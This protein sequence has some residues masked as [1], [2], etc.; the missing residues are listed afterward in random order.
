MKIPCFADH[1][2][3]GPFEHLDTVGLKIPRST[4]PDQEASNTTHKPHKLSKLNIAVIV[5]IVGAIALSFLCALPHLC[6]DASS[7]KKKVKAEKEKEEKKDKEKNERERKRAAWLGQEERI[8]ES[9][10]A[11]EGAPFYGFRRV[12]S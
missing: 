8:V 2:T 11:E 4:K 6:R 7:V 12:W 5:V 1:H 3:W 10:D 9:D